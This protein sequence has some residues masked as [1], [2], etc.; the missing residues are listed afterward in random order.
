M[1]AQII[2]TLHTIQ[3]DDEQ[4]DIYYDFPTSTFQIFIEGEHY[5]TSIFNPARQILSYN[6]ILDISTTYAQQHKKRKQRHEQQQ[7]NEQQQQENTT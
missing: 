1:K 6:N 3:V 4:I 5:L 7:Q 2:S